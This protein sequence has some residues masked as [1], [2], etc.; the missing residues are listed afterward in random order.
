VDISA[1]TGYEQFL[2][3]PA[4]TTVGYVLAFMPDN[5][6]WPQFEAGALAATTNGVAGTMKATDWAPVLA[7]RK[8]MLAVPACCG[9]T[10]WADEASGAND[11][12]W[13]ALTK[14]LVSGGLAGCDLRIARE[15]TGSWYRWHANPVNA[16]Q[17]TAGYTHVCKL[18]R[19]N[20]FTGQF[21]WNAYAGLGSFTSFAQIEALFPAWGN[22][23]LGLDFYDGPSP[24]YPVGE[25]IRTQAQQ[26]AVWNNILS[27]PGGLEDWYN[28]ARSKQLAFSYPEWGLRLWTDGGKY[29]GGGDNALLIR[30]MAAWVK[31][32]KPFMHGFWEDPDVGV[33]D[34]DWHPRR[35]IAVPAARAEFLHQFGWTQP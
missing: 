8:L 27:G 13:L 7:G 21:I 24:S 26:Q 19:A 29:A 12:H 9:G 4:S 6:T 16:A 14:T 17:Y 20:G 18:I 34:P 30:E 32:A 15:F 3:M 31:M 23:N 22:G 25:E 5:P 1:I 35:F 2:G 10:T 11:A 28:F 33:S